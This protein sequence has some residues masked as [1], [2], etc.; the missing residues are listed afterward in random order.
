MGPF[1]GMVCLGGIALA[2]WLV[3]RKLADVTVCYLCQSI[4]RGLPLN[5][6]HRGFYLGLEE[7]H[8]KLRQRWLRDLLG[9]GP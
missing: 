4:Y 2:D 7:K 6:A 3:Y 8:K 1:E 9:E 5:E